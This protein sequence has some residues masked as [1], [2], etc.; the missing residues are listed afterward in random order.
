MNN[1]KQDSAC[2]SVDSILASPDYKRE[3]LL[4]LSTA[5]D[6]RQTE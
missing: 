2:S 5:G 1:L 3:L 6:V 4:L